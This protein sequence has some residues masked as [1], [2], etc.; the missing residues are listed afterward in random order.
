[1]KT[2]IGVFFGG[3]SVEHEVAVISALQAIQNID[4]NLYDITP[5]YIAK[6]GKML[7]VKFLQKEIV[8]TALSF[9]N[10]IMNFLLT[11]LTFRYIINYFKDYYTI[12][13]IDY[14][15]LGKSPIPTNTLNIYNYAELINE[16]TKIITVKNVFFAD[17]TFLSDFS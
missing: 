16:F 17:K 13:I 10:E 14:P 9:F 8:C 3:N 12:Y 5:I 7:F 15:G 11:T 6:N 1:M 2:N 4:K